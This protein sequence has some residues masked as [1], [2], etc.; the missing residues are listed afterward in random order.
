M[1]TSESPVTLDPSLRYTVQVRR[2]IFAGHR[3]L[4]GER[5]V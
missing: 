5:H 4:K 3:Q 2:Q 1:L